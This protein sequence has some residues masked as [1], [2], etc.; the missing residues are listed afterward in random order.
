MSTAAIWIDSIHAKVFEFIGNGVKFSRVP[1]DDS[2]F[3]KIVSRILADDALVI[4]GPETT[5][6]KFKEY[7]DRHFPSLGK[8]VVKEEHFEEL[9]DRQIIAYAQGLLPH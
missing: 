6:L 5:R 9:P 3:E 7:L 8:K 2:F 1:H 4:L